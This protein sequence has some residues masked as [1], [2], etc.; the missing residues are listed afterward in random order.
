MVNMDAVDGRLTFTGY[1]II[2]DNHYAGFIPEDESA[3]LV[4]LLGRNIVRIRTVQTSSYLATVE[5]KCKNKQIRPQYVDGQVVFN[6]DMDFSAQLL[7]MDKNTIV[8]KHQAEVI[9][10]ELQTVLMGEIVQ[11]IQRSQAEGCDYLELWDSFRIHYPDVIRQLDW[12]A[13]Y[14]NAA[15]HISVSADLDPGGLMDMQAQGQKVS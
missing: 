11:T 9:K 6:I 1:T 13:A 7:Y 2:K 4:W 8:D 12:P 10:N 14:Q 15:F 5:V 3:G